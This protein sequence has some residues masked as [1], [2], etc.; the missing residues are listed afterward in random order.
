MFANEGRSEPV[1][2]ISRSFGR[3]AVLAVNTGYD[4]PKDLIFLEMK[5]LRQ[6][7]KDKT[8]TRGFV[9]KGANPVAPT[10]KTN[11]HSS[12]V[13]KGCFSLWECDLRKT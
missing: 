1:R 3:P 11:S 4:Q 6:Y 5:G 10:L 13:M 7:L 9:H 8:Q 2:Q 12:I